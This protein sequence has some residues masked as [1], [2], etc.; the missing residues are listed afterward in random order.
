MNYYFERRGR[1]WGGA[2]RIILKYFIVLHF[3]LNKKTCKV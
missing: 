3:F 2:A 1:G